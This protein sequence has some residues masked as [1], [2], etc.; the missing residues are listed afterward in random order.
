[1]P[2]CGI[3]GTTQSRLNN[4]D[5]C[6]LCNNDKKVDNDTITETTIDNNKLP[7]L[8]TSGNDDDSDDRNIIEVIKQC[9]INE[10]YCENDLVNSYKGQ[11]NYL[12]TELKYKN[13]LIEKLITELCNKQN[14]QDVQSSLE[15][16]MCLQYESTIDDVIDISSAG[17]NR[18]NGEPEV[19]KQLCTDYLQWHSIKKNGKSSMN[20]NFSNN[21][22]EHDNILSLNKYRSLVIDDMSDFDN[23]FEKKLKFPSMTVYIT[24]PNVKYKRRRD[25]KW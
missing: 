17:G 8:N 4:G 15:T 6:K 21:D 16:S 12:K 20:R 11:V 3:C 1:M 10:K 18:E 23:E 5:L 9:M 24:S 25:H 22:V 19:P 13:E 14:K 2:A 7:I